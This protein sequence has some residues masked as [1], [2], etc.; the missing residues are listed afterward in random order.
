M[1][2]CPP[3][4]EQEET[5]GVEVAF[6]EGLFKRASQLGRESDETRKSDGTQQLESES[7]EVEEGRQ[8]E[9]APEGEDE[10]AEERGIA[11]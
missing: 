7:D 9:R 2:H 1:N 10:G 11:S 3:D 4:L 5:Q 8:G 6:P